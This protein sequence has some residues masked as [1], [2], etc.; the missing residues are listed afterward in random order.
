MIKT[1]RIVKAFT[2][3]GAGCAMGLGH[4]N[5]DVH[6]SAWNWE[7]DVNGQVGAGALFFPC[8]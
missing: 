3:D 6:V 1:E 5:V 2:F 4:Q 8:F 7:K